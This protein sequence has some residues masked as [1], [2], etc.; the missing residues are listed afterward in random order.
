M[1]KLTLAKRFFIVGWKPMEM[2]SHSIEFPKL[3][4]YLEKVHN[5][6]TK[7]LLSSGWWR[8]DVEFKS[9]MRDLEN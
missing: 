6:I 9:G 1:T 2:L 3:Y 8:A 7:F 4:Y 5:Q